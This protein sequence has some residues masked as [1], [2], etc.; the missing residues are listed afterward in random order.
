MPSKPL[1]VYPAE[2]K[3][4]A[5]FGER[6]KLARLRRNFSV[7]V[8]ALR[9]GVSRM[10]IYRAEKGSG[11]VSI[12]VYLRILWVLKLQDDF[13]ALAADD[14]MG[15]RLQDIGLTVGKRARKVESG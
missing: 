1:P 10:T 12:G 9:T 7:D 14:R 5:A 2:K 8:V 3:Q 4:L 11:A 6:L 13:D 15:R